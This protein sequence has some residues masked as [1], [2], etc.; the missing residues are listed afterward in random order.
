[1]VNNIDYFEVDSDDEI[2]EL[3]IMNKNEFKIHH[4]LKYFLFTVECFKMYCLKSTTEKGELVRKY[5]SKLESL[6][7]KFH[8]D[9]IQDSNQKEQILLNNQR[10][11]KSKYKS[12]EGI[13]CWSKIGDK[14]G[15]YRIGRASDIYNRLSQHDSSNADKIFVHDVKYV[16]CSEMIETNV[17]NFLDYY[18]YRGEFYD[19]DINMIKNVFDDTIEM[20]KKYNSACTCLDSE[21]ENDIKIKDNNIKTKHTNS[22]K[23][24]SKK[25]N[26]KNSKKNI[27]K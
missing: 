23:K 15:Y 7:R 3:K 5:Y 12:E 10:N 14:D 13:Y 8:L 9:Y 27:K 1:L 18:K 11:S 24:N 26:K 2:K 20:M 6:F 21:C 17:K 25:N 16:K 19:C 4:N 22:S